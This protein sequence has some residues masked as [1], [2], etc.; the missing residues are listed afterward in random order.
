MHAAIKAQYAA[1]GAIV[2]LGDVED[3]TVHLVS[4]GGVPLAPNVH[5]AEASGGCIERD[6]LPLQPPQR[7]KPA[8]PAPRALRARGALKHGTRRP[9]RVDHA[10]NGEAE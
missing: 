8:H 4:E 9:K 10:Q 2:I 7:A 3:H 5:A 6:V 1:Y